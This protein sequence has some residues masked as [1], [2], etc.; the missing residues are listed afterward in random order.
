MDVLV[1]DMQDVGVRFYT[2]LSTLFYVLRGAAKSSLPVIVLDRPN[3]I[4]GERLEGPLVAPG[5][6]SFVGIAP[7]PIRHGMTLGELARTFNQTLALGAA[8][9][10][11]EMQGWQRRMWF[12]ETGL[13]WIPTSPAM[14]Q[15]STA[16]VYPG[17]CFVEGTN[18]SEGRGTAL[19]FE[20]VGAPWLDGYRLAQT[21]NRLDLPGVR[22][23]PVHFEPSASKHAGRHCE[24]VQVH[25]TDRHRLDTVAVGLHSIAACQAQAPEQFAYL[26]T[27]WEGH[28]PHFD[29]LAGSARLREGLAAGIP[30]A[31]LVAAWQTELGT[32]AEA[33]QQ[34][35]LYA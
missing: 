14:P 17:L 31:D 2:Y 18:L 23:R 24:G 15:L 1:F 30:V 22:F 34:Y 7:L 35:L 4:G 26:E 16:T 3:P 33:R 9:T 20:Q 21:L 12:D 29:L 19:P 13:P 8:L 10:V 32:F 6:E 27:S 25:V 28:P 11:V 5:Y